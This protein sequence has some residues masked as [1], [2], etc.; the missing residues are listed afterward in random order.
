MNDDDF[1]VEVN[2]TG[3]TVLVYSLSSHSCIMT[4]THIRP[5]MR[6]SSGKNSKTQAASS[7]ASQPVQELEQ[8]MESWMG[9]SAP[10]ST[11]AEEASEALKLPTS[12]L[13]TP[14]YPSAKIG[15]GTAV[16]HSEP[17]A[18]PHG[19][20][21]EATT[22]SASQLESQ[23]EPSMRTFAPVVCEQFVIERDPFLPKRQNRQ[24]QKEQTSHSAVE[25]YETTVTSMSNPVQPKEGPLDEATPSKR[26][27]EIENMEVESTQSNGKEDPMVILNS[28]EELFE[29]AGEVLPKDRTTITSDTKLVEADMAFSVMTQEQYGEK[30][31]HLRREM[32]AEREDVYNMFMGTEDIFE[33]GNRS[34]VDG[35]DDDSEGEEE[36]LNFMME[37]EMNGEGEDYSEEDQETILE[38][39]PRAFALIWTAFA[40]WLTPEAVEWMARLEHPDKS[41][42]KPLYRNGWTPQVDRS[43]IGASRCAGLMA[44]IKMY[45]PSSM[46]ALNHPD[47]MRRI[48]E[49]RIGD[50]L[51]TFDYSSEAPKLPTKLW[52]AITCIL[53]DMVLLETRAKSVETIPQS[54]ET[55]GMTLD[56]Y[57]YLTRT[58]VQT[59]Q[60][61]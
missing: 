24:K 57:K 20:V 58:A 19:G 17:A 7:S 31:T 6:K 14:K 11:T 5:K 50:F 42:D 44:M 47:D 55:V 18:E 37:Q 39:T 2:F 32:E 34:Q 54:V 25:G 8:K 21:D 49:H 41:S 15:A 29:A 35:S 27:N 33:G 38:A 16:Q 40:E 26:N 4:S 13:K 61:S 12:I 48:A 1:L 51:R 46:E 60:P 45:L 28:V 56:E 30:V 10:P 22:E 53:L 23:P 9:I 36:F 3:K 52:K 43:D 59:F